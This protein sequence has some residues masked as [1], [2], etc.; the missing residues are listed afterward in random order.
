M[1]GA[2]EPVRLLVVD[3]A[4][5]GGGLERLGRA[6]IPRLAA[7][8]EQ[9]IWCLPEHKL[10]AV[11]AE[12]GA[13]DRLILVSF[14]WPRGTAGRVAAGLKRRGDALLTRVGLRLPQCIATQLAEARI[15]RIVREH[16]VTCVHY[17]ALFDQPF[18][19]LGVPVTATVADVNYHPDWLE[20]CLRNLEVW[21]RRA[22]KLIAISEFT[23]D[24]IERLHPAVSPRLHAVPLAVEPPQPA[25]R[26]GRSV[27]TA[28]K[29]YY[30]ATVNAHKRHGLLLR[31][32]HMLHARG[33][34]VQVQLTGGETERLRDMTGPASPAV[35]E[36]RRILAATP[37]AFR[38]RVQALGYVTPEEVERCYAEADVVALPSSVEGFGLP[39]SEAVVRG[40]TTVCA[41]IPAFREQAR[42]YGFESAV[43]FVAEATPEAWAA[44]LEKAGRTARVLTGGVAGFSFERW[45]WTDVARAQ[46]QVFR[47]AAGSASTL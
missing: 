32:A 22:T 17:A 23:R 36:C 38:N 13:H 6:L 33:F 1:N 15:R 7:Q 28:L 46:V 4:I 44:A 35:A 47:A 26:H 21:S 42:L 8:C 18:P 29:I 25:S 2:E 30:P 14:A 10:E 39:L 3:E 24:E 11:R 27:E 20:R 43:T 16:R 19:R 5:A 9:V 31:A 12:V 40:K 45:T 34:E 37:E 41:D